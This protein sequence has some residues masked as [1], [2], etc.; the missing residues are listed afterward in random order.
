MQFFTGCTSGL[1]FS[2]ITAAIIL[3]QSRCFIA[4]CDIFVNYRESIGD[5][6]QTVI[7]KVNEKLSKYEKIRSFNVMDMGALLKG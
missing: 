4:T 5:D 7:D 3:L 1:H 6:W 2:H